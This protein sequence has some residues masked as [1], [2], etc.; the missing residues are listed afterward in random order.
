VRPLSIA[1]EMHSPVREHPRADHYAGLGTSRLFHETT[2][3]DYK[4]YA[5]TSIQNADFMIHARGLSQRL[6]E[7]E[8]VVLNIPVDARL[9][10]YNPGMPVYSIAQA[11]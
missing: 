1:D 6:L 2:V 8:S 9:V 4:K 10:G 3:A 7:I 5:P 11:A